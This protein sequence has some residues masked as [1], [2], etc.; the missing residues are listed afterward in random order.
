[1]KPLV[2]FNNNTKKIIFMAPAWLYAV[3]RS[4]PT[5]PPASHSKLST[6]ALRGTCFY[7]WR[8]PTTR[9]SIH[10]GS[11]HCERSK[12]KGIRQKAEGIRRKAEGR[13]RKAKDIKCLKTN[14]RPNGKWQISKYA[15]MQI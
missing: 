4:R 14:K 11:P 6:A 12:A 3:L 5:Y 8:S 1:M 13:R 10:I 9:K 2:Q 15:K 7:P